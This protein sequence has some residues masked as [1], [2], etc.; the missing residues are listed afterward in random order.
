M[1]VSLHQ[2]RVFVTLA[3]H[4]SFTRTADASGVTQ[5]AVSRSIRDLEAEIDLRLFDRTTR[6]V[7]LTVAGE[8]LLKR[9]APLVDEIEAVLR[10]SDGRRECE[11][12][13]VQIASVAQASSAFVV[14]ALAACRDACP[15]ISVVLR[16]GAQASVLQLV[17]S[18]MADLGVVV[19]PANLDGLVAEPLF[20]E[21]LCA[22]LPARHPLGAHATLQWT[23]L[24]GASLI[25]LDDA[26]G[27]PRIERALASHDV[28]NAALHELAYPA[29][30]T[31]MV[32]A[33]LGIGIAPARA[34][35]DGLADGIVLRALYPVL[36]RTTMLVRRKNRSL[37]PVA[38]TVWARLMATAG[39]G[40][41]E[42][43]DGVQSVGVGQAPDIEAAMTDSALA[44]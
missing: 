26:G 28:P 23:H 18:G 31:Q 4:R 30:L 38:A 3:R 32:R 40:A 44:R 5:S 9:V 19:D 36:E 17:L 41:A 37:R 29:A 6:Q 33:G 1:N 22:V 42:R 13:L 8:N 20:A 21:S 43:Q 12:G 34:F 11:R 7:E 24:R 39:G 27:R 16:D 2:L 10:D 14:Q 25:V 35:P 15:D